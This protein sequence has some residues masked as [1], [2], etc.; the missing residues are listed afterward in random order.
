M[1][2]FINSR[3]RWFGLLFLLLALGMLAWGQLVLGARLR[4]LG[5]I[6]YWLA[7]M[8]FTLLALIT[9]LLDARA[10]RRQVRREQEELLRRAVKDLEHRS[11][12]GAPRRPKG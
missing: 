7:C 9:A 12:P 4:G 6:L 11:P 1:T 8:G 5:Y 10:T 2:G 3:L